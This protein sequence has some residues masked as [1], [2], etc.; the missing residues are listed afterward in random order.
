LTNN[1]SDPAPPVLAAKSSTVMCTPADDAASP[2]ASAAHVTALPLAHQAQ[3]DAPTSRS[4]DE[5]EPDGNTG[6]LAIATISL[7]AR[8]GG[9]HG[10]QVAWAVSLLLH[11]AALAVA[12]Q[13]T[14]VH[15]PWLMEIDRGASATLAL[16]ASLAPT[17]PEPPAFELSELRPPVPTEAV[18][19]DAPLPAKPRKQV[20]QPSLLTPAVNV[21]PA[22]EPPSQI[23]ER[24]SYTPSEP[25]LAQPEIESPTPTPARRRQWPSEALAAVVTPPA[26]IPANDRAGAQLDTPP[27]KLPRNPPP[28]YPESA[29]RAGQEGRVTLIAQVDRSGQV[30]QVAVHSSSGVPELDR[31][32]IRTV[33]LWRFQPALNG[34]KPVASE[35]MVPIKF[36]LRPAG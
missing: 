18:E 30:T 4:V 19:R 22:L 13:W 26:P 34:G 27:R 3:A 15:T 8:P 11:L 31:E 10:N 14:A 32:A 23:A 16:T 17:A 2:T 35:I 24:V 1:P 36:S 29:R 28:L 21:D 25:A 9:S 12:G 20:Q 5:L 33:S 6:P 7:H